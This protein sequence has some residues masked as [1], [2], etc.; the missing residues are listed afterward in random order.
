MKTPYIVKFQPKDLDGFQTSSDLKDFVNASIMTHDLNLLLIG[1]PGTGKTSL[2]NIIISLYF[3]DAIKDKHIYETH[4]LFI[5]SLREQGISFYRSEVRTFCQTQSV[6]PCKKKI[7]ILDDVDFINE[8]SQQVFRSCMDKYG[9]NVNFLISCI[10]TQKVI[11]SL[12]SRTTLVRLPVLTNEQLHLIGSNIVRSEGI[13]IDSDAYDYLIKISNS[14]V[15]LVTNYLEK[16]KILDERITLTLVHEICSN[17]NYHFFEEFIDSCKDGD[18]RKASDILYTLSDRG[19]SVMDILDSL[20]QYIKRD[21]NMTELAKYTLMPT[22]CKYISIFHEIHEDDIELILLTRD[23]VKILSCDI[24]GK[25][26]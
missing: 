16:M 25:S 8:Q 5:N 13:D 2:L 21:E 12:Q 7:V 22:I 24:S 17:I 9:A 10:N 3:G 26:P 15:R 20:T 1:D 4:I 18:V 23:I 6:I 11:E 14:S 19:F